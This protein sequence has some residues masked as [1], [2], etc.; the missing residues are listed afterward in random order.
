MTEATS[1]LWCKNGFNSQ[2]RVSAGDNRVKQ[3]A[4]RSQVLG[5]FVAKNTMRDFL[6]KATGFQKRKCAHK[7]KFSGFVGF[8]ETQ[9]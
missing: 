9:V 8:F 2:I 1:H 6:G 7:Y 3:R 5:I 4:E